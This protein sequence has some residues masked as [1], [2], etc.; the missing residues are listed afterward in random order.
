MAGLGMAGLDADCDQP[1]TVAPADSTKAKI[2]EAS[3][4]AAQKRPGY[5]KKVVPPMKKGAGNAGRSARP[6]PRACCHAND[7]HTAL[8][9]GMRWRVTISRRVNVTVQP[10]RNPQETAPI[11]LLK[12]KLGRPERHGVMLFRLAVA[13]VSMAVLLVHPCDAVSQD[14]LRYVDLN[15]PEMSTSEMTRAEVDELLKGAT[16]GPGDQRSA[17]LEGKRLSHLDL[18]GLDFSGS[19]LRLAKLN[20]TDLKGA[21]F[22]RAILNQAWLIDADLTGA[23]LVKASLLSTQMQRAKLGGADLRGARITGDLSGASL[24]GARLA[25]ADLSADMRNQSMGLMRGVLK[26]ADLSNADLSG[27][28]LSRANLEFAKLQNANLANCNL[29]HAD[30]AGADLSNANLAGADFTE[31]DLD[32]T[33]LPSADRLADARNLDRAWNLNLA[34]RPP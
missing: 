9:R 7:A 26:S 8:H 6:Q 13:L 15:S 20:R 18:S 24:I 3:I 11:F 25:G 29:N 30:L 1:C 2:V 10:T 28:N 23:S 32:S 19:N 5:A 16:Q 34:R 21:R 31:T 22:D 4:L 17:D 27:A 12:L 14:L 33:L